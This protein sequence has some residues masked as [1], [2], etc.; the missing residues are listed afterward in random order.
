M[1]GAGSSSGRNRQD[2]DVFQPK[3]AEEFMNW[4][5]SLKVPKASA[6][7]AFATAHQQQGAY[8]QDG[9]Q[10]L[11]DKIVQFAANV[12]EAAP[13]GAEVSL[14][15]NGHVQVDGHG[16]CSVSLSFYPPVPTS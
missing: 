7:E 12:A 2:R 3:T 16:S 1:G 13:D 11:M 15:S 10:K 8:S 6:R 9:P 14:S 5:L 4:S